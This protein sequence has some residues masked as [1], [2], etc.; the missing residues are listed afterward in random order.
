MNNLTAKVLQTL[1]ISSALLVIGSGIAIAIPYDCYKW[2]NNEPGCKAFPNDCAWVPATASCRNSASCFAGNQD[3][4]GSII[5]CYWVPYDL[6]I[7]APGYC[8]PEVC[9]G[10]D[11]L[12]CEDP[13]KPWCY[14]WGSGKGNCMPKGL[15]SADGGGAFLAPFDGISGAN[16]TVKKPNFKKTRTKHL[17]VKKLPIK[18]RGLA[19]HI[20]ELL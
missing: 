15:M 1:I 17:P 11:K 10:T 4:C 9:S 7:P 8:A 12:S 18:K 20:L 2:L 13:A 5:G 19:A 16:K 6:E 14:W 3:A